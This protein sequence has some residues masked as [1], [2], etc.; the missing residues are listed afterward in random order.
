[1]SLEIVAIYSPP[2]ELINFSFGI[3]IL[4]NKSLVELPCLEI[5][6]G[7]HGLQPWDGLFKEFIPSALTVPSFIQLTEVIHLLNNLTSLMILR[8]HT[9]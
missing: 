9:C 6:D 5:R 2:V 8:L 4:E 1:M 7:P 3:L